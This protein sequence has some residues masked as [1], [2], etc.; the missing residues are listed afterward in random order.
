[1]ERALITGDHQQKQ[2]FWKSTYNSINNFSKIHTSQTD[3]FVSVHES[4]R[5]IDKYQFFYKILF[6][7]KTFL[8]I[9]VPP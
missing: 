9:P 6:C 1:M 7:Y 2:K 8:I 5:A 4:Y 3:I